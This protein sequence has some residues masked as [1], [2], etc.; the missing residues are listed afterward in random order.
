[1]VKLFLPLLWVRMG[2]L[3]RV[4]VWIRRLRFGN[5]ARRGRYERWLE[6]GTGLGLTY[7]K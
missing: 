2:S 1:M 5:V 4:R 3:W 7:G 6:V